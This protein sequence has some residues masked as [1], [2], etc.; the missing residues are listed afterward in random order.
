MAKKQIAPQRNYVSELL[1]FLNIYGATSA[2][3]KDEWIA[4]GINTFRWTSS[5]RM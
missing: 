4:A 1:L 5:S 2:K 3:N